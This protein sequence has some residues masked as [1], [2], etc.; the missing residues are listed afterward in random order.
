MVL[1]LLRTC[2][3][4]SNVVL[5]KMSTP[6]V[7]RDIRIVFKRISPILHVI[8]IALI[9]KIPLVAFHELREK[10]KESCARTRPV[11]LFDEFYNI[12]RG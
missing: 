5:T 11:R 10:K 2:R 1:S 9:L 7:M 3:R 8:I 6:L 12:T 4:L